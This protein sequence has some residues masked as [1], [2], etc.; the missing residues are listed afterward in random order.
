VAD[1]A[2]ADGQIGSVEQAPR[3]SR[4]DFAGKAHYGALTEAGS[5]QP[6]KR[7]LNVG[8]GRRPPG[9]VACTRVSAGIQAEAN[10]G[11]RGIQVRRTSL[12]FGTLCVGERSSTS[13]I[14][15]L[16]DAQLIGVR[17]V[18]RNARTAALRAL[19]SRSHQCC[20]PPRSET[21][22]HDHEHAEHHEGRT[23]DRRLVWSKCCRRLAHMESLERA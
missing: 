3:G 12:G 2:R 21:Y 4:I 7:G 18:E 16:P 19:G 14:L 10:A 22:R 20:H 17:G 13:L 15:S 6:L 8:R 5:L 1:H 23:T 11:D 9:D